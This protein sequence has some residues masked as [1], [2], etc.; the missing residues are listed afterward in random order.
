MRLERTGE[1]LGGKLR[2]LVGVEHLWR[3]VADNGLL[4]RF[5]AKGGVHRVREPMREHLTAVPVDHGHEIEKA[6]R[7]R[8]VRNVRRIDLPRSRN[9]HASEQIRINLVPFSR[10]R[11]AVLG[12]DGP[13][14]HQAHEANDAASG[15]LAPTCLEHTLYRA[16]SARGTLH[17]ESV[18]LLHNGKVLFA[19]CARG[20][21]GRRTTQFDKSRLANHGHG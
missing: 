15:D 11:R 6:F 12:V 9:L 8:D 13:K 21:V 17:V 18:D 10:R 19:L 5:D 14:T 20:V 2:S 3:A 4:H 1:R 16:R 7:H